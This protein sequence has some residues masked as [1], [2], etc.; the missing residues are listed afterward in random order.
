MIYAPWVHSL[1]EKRMIVKSICAKVKNKFNVSIAEVE[2]QDT[3]Q[4]IVL[5][6]ACVAGEASMADSMID[7]VLNFIES[8]ITNYNNLVFV[9]NKVVKPNKPLSMVNYNDI[10]TK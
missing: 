1:K 4:N 10:F 5:G 9:Y 8:T 3:H 2:E 7:H 6:F